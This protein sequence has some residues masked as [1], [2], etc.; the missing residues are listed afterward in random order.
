M[1]ELTRLAASIQEALRAQGLARIDGGAEI[2]HVELSAPAARDDADSRNFV[3][4]SGGEYDRSPCGTGTSARM[5]VLHARGEQHVVVALA[6]GGLSTP[7]VFGELDRLR[8]ERGPAEQGDGRA[9]PRA[10]GTEQLVQA[11]AGEDPAAVA[12][13]LANDMEPATL[14]LMP[15]LR[16]TLRAGKEAGA[17]G[18]MVSGSGLEMAG[19][20]SAEFSSDP[21]ELT[22]PRD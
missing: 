5:A 13:L 19:E 3:L 16:R 2:D 8:A 14:S 4:C 10:G 7:L 9:L 11:L 15:A 18:G 12:A 1:G 17:L 6:A 21:L 20:T 22:F